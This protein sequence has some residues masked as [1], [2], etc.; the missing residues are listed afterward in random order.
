MDPREPAAIPESLAYLRD[1]LGPA[2]TASPLWPSL[3]RL[4]WVAGLPCAAAPGYVY[5]A[6]SIHGVAVGG[7]GGTLAEA[8]SRLSGEAAEVAAR[9]SGAAPSSLPGD[10]AIDAIWRRSGNVPRVAAVDLADGRRLGVPAAAILPAPATGPQG[11]A[12]P[13]G[14]GLAA[15]PDRAAARLAGLMELIERDAIAAWWLDGARPRRLDPP[16]LDAAAARLARLRAG[17][18]VPRP[19]GFLSLTSPTGMPVV[20][21]LSRDASGR[22]M[23]FGFKAAFD[24]LAA[25]DGAIMELLQMEIALDLARSRAARDAPTPEDL[26]VLRRADLDSNAFA[27]FAPSPA[28]SSG[29]RLS[30]LGGVVSGLA[31]RG[32][33]VVAVDLAGPLGGLAVAKVLATGLRPFPGGQGARRDAPGAVAPLM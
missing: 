19:S 30:S 7:G 26:R 27:C 11:D 13:S 8:A 23:A 15:G 4:D 1:A 22:G 33:R 6:G 29:H 10:P 31:S 24:A 18:P 16:A 2:A 14:L 17:A 32:C 25:A 5:L 21:A 3:S 28:V 20:C 9:H 12:P